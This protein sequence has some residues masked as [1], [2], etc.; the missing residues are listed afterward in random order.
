M[1][2]TTHTVATFK[3]SLSVF[4]AVS[5]RPTSAA[6]RSGGHER[7]GPRKALHFDLHCVRQNR[8]KETEIGSDVALTAAR[9]CSFMTHQAS[10]AAFSLIREECVAFRP[11][12]SREFC[13]GLQSSIEPICFSNASLRYRVSL[14]ERSLLSSM[15]MSNHGNPATSETKSILTYCILLYCTAWHCIALPCTA[16]HC[17]ALHCTAC[18]RAIYSFR[19]LMNFENTFKGSDSN[20][21][22]DKRLQNVGSAVTSTTKIPLQ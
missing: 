2:Q 7:F 8:E 3:S 21:F 1:V 5:W 10:E 15:D 13:N 12:L 6:G 20:I 19:L 18:N 11:L 22:G 14:G 16:L 17:I 9:S 4:N